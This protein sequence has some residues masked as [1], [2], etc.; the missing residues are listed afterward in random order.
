MGTQIVPVQVIPSGDLSKLQTA[1]TELREEDAKLQ[2]LKLEAQAYAVISS[3]ADSEAAAKIVADLRQR[4]KI[5][6]FKINP[7]LA[8][9]EQVAVTLR[10]YRDKHE[11]TC[12]EIAEPLSRAIVAWDEQERK[13]A[14][15]EQDEINRKRRADAALLAEVERKAREKQ[16][17]TD[18]KERQKEI[19][20]SRKAG[21]LTAKGAAKLTQQASEAAERQ[22]EDAAQQAEKT[23]KDVKL[24]EVKP[25]LTK[26][27]GLR[28]AVTWFFKIVDITKVP[29]EFLYPTRRDDGSYDPA[30]FPVI[31]DHVRETKDKGKAEAACPG[32]V[33][34]SE[35]KV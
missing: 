16:A 28:R 32:I 35:T 9:V 2:E 26:V 24:V 18:R 25:D 33:V 13:A 15:A 27:A 19:D 7:F 3:K 29:R 11:N 1:L 10:D 5:G 34:W 31:G 6:G 20:A 21:D 4:K 17:E 8:I 22:K 12:K 23:A 14:L 30:K